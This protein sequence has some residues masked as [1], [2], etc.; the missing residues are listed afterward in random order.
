MEMMFGAITLAPQ[1]TASACLNPFRSFG[2]AA[3]PIINLTT[4][5]Y[6]RGIKNSSQVNCRT[7]NCIFGR[8]NILRCSKCGASV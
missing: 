1:E 8:L 4:V 3:L 7:M 6:N 5:T 2:L